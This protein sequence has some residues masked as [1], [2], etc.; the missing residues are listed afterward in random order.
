MDTVGDTAKYENELES[1]FAGKG[2]KFVVSSKADDIF[3]VVSAASICAK[4]NRDSI[5]REWKFKEW[6]KTSE[7]EPNRTF[8]YKFGC[9]YPGDSDTRKWLINHQN[10][11]FG[12][13]SIVR[14]SWKTVH[15]VMSGTPMGNTRWP[16]VEEKKRRER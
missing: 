14:F 5:L 12:F 7:G 4:V 9:G 15:D 11:I 3:P 16:D 8:S 13:P 10:K 2:I 1:R 6:H